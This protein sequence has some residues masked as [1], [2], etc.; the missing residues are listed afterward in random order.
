MSTDIKSSLDIVNLLHRLRF[1]GLALALL[2]ETPLLKFLSGVTKGK[3]VK[4]PEIS[5]DSIKWEAN[6]TLSMRDRILV[7]MVKK[8]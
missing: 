1:H 2:L 4:D 6:D 7:F 3:P 8:L 5:K